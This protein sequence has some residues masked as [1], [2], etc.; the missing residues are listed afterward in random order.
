MTNKTPS[1]PLQSGEKPSEHA[2]LVEY[3]ACQHEASATGSYS[4]QS[5]IIFFVT[6]LTLAGVAIT[7]LA[8][9]DTSLYRFL[10]IFALGAFSITLLYAW[11]TYL[12]R[13]HLIRNIMFDR[14]RMIEKQKGLRKNLYVDFLDKAT[15]NDWKSEKWS[16][17]EEN[18][19]KMLWE[20][21]RKDPGRKPRG[22][23]WV[24]WVTWAAIIAW[25]VVLVL[26]LLNYFRPEFYQ[27]FLNIIES[28]RNG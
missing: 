28:W 5:G 22:F 3:Q 2:L 8:R 13:Q 17:L 26:T 24:S 6:T 11:N 16:P 1:E 10:V 27:N 20:K 23:K 18:E 15:E 14:M 25:V 7:L 21:Y 12:S 4:W 19:R 9:A